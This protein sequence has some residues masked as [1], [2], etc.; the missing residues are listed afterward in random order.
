M[1]NEDRRDVR[2]DR[3]RRK[4]IEEVIESEKT[5]IARENEIF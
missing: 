4:K 1:V 2:D 5:K 3:E